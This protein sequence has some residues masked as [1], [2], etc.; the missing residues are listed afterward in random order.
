[1]SLFGSLRTSYP[2]AATQTGRM[3]TVSDSLSG[4]QGNGGN[5]FLSLI[6]GGTTSPEGSSTGSPSVYSTLSREA[7]YRVSLIGSLLDGGN[8]GGAGGDTVDD[9]AVD[10]PAI[11][12]T[13]DLEAGATVGYDASGSEEVTNDLQSTAADN[14]LPKV[15]DDDGDEVENPIAEVGGVTNALPKMDAPPA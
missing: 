4:G 10:N 7:A 12:A 1:M 6:D 15:G 9:V 11:E 2:A 8:G 14:T 13:G 5:E 3:P